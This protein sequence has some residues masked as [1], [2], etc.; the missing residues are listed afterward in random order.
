MELL[1]YDKEKRVS[2]ITLTDEEFVDIEILVSYIASTFS[3]HDKTLLFGVDAA[4]LKDIQSKMDIVLEGIGKEK[5][6]RK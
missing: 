4:R 1:N 2:T 6:L 3:K 5:K